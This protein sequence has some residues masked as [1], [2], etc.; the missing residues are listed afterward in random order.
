MRVLKRTMSVQAIKVLNKYCAMFEF[1]IE[2]I[3]FIRAEVKLICEYIYIYIYTVCLYKKKIPEYKVFLL[4]F[5]F[6]IRVGPA[7]NLLR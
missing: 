4:T 3:V 2:I 5:F 7:I 6:N 1:G